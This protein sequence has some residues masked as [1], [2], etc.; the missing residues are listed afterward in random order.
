M[1]PLVRLHVDEPL[2]A[3][4]TTIFSF[5]NGSLGIARPAPPPRLGPRPKTSGHAD[6]VLGR[7]LIG[8]INERHGL[9]VIFGPNGAT[10]PSNAP[11]TADIEY[12]HLSRPN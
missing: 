3:G 2:E 1:A 11:G 10:Q 7:R 8:G 12:G 9:H 4:Q 6:I 5:L